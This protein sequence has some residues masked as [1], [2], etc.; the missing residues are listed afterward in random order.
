[1]K[2]RRYPLVA[3][4]VI[5]YKQIRWLVETGLYTVSDNIS[6]HYYVGKQT[7]GPPSGNRSSPSI[8]T[9]Y[10]RIITHTN[11]LKI[12]TCT[13]SCSGNIYR[14][15]IQRSELSRKEISVKLNCFNLLGSCIRVN[16]PPMVNSEM[17]HDSLN[18]RIIP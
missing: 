14:E 9:Y 5:L 6:F 18:Y 13:L 2:D 1:M 7:C 4:L 16:T 17:V 3:I 15:L 10:T 8:E 11:A 12:K